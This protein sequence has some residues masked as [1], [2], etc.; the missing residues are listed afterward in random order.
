MHEWNKFVTFKTWF[1]RR[2]DDFQRYIFNVLCIIERDST[3]IGAAKPPSKK[4]RHVA[5]HNKAQK[6]RKD[7]SSVHLKNEWDIDA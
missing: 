7:L 1:I 3:A 4:L 5:A 2:P 6:I